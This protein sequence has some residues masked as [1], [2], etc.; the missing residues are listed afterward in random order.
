LGP[1]PKDP[2]DY[3]IGEVQTGEVALP[4]E[5]SLRSQMTSVKNQNPH[6]ICFR[7][8]T[9]VLMED[10]SYKPIREI[11][12]GEYVFTHFGNIKRVS[13]KIIRKWQGTTK[14]IKLWG[15]FR[16]I[17]STSEHPFL[18]IKRSP[19]NHIKGYKEIDGQIDFYGIDEL[20]RGD[21]LAYPFNNIVLDKT[22]Y[23]LEKDPEFLWLLGI[24]LAE[25]SMDGNEINFSLHQ[26]ETDY[27]EKIISIF[28]KYNETANIQIH[29]KT[30][31]MD[32]RVSSKRFAKLLKELGGEMCDKK[33]LNNRLMFLEP[34]LQMEIVRGLFDGD[35]TKQ[36]T[37]D[38]LTTT[39]LEL[40]IQVKTILLRNKIMSCLQE[41]K[42]TQIKNGLKKPAWHLTPSNNYKISFIK[43]NWCFVLIKDIKHNKSYNGGSVYNLEV[44]DDNS[45]QV[46][47]VAVHNCYQM[48][49]T[50]VK[51]FWDSKEAGKEIDLSER[52]GVYNTKQLS[53][54]WYT[55]GDYAHYAL[56]AICDFGLCLEKDWPTDTSIPWNE[57]AK[58]RPVEGFFVNAKEFK[59]LTYWRVDHTVESFKQTIY[60]QQAPILVGMSWDKAYN[61]PYLGGKLPLPSG[62]R[63]GGHFVT[64]VG[65]DSLGLWFKNSWGLAWG[66]SG[67]FYIPESEFDKHDIWDAYVLLDQPKKEPIEGWVAIKYLDGVTYGQGS[68]VKTLNNLTLRKEPSIMGEKLDTLKKGNMVEVVSGEIKAADGYIWQKIKT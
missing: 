12:V 4:A 61:I 22:I 45:Y 44:E 26:K 20:K 68:I 18:A 24:Y 27:A 15:D 42:S 65:W 41:M 43:D 38:M 14:I 55:Q 48:A 19:K 46:N 1:D 32:V 31:G 21:W 5:F 34:S 3:K 59:G 28:K 8:D 23:S 67:Y 60:Q 35:A 54:I 47:G 10:L 63:V 36:K 52:F 33:R 17:E 9:P 62:N 29:K 51:E 64:C 58:T 11:N 49:A 56:K 37:G 50:G 66:D 30:L 13:N 39:S 57:F 16:E 7:G 40:M 2:R 6:G 53:N 25:G